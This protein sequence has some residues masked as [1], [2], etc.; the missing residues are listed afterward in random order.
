MATQLQRFAEAL[1]PD[2]IRCLGRALQP[3]SVGHILLLARLEHPLVLGRGLYDV[4]SLA[5]GVAVC[6]MPYDRVVA[7]RDT[8]WFRCWLHWLGVK[9]A[10]DLRARSVFTQYLIQGAT[11]PKSCVRD[12]SGNTP[13]AGTPFWCSVLVTMQGDLGMSLSQALSVPAARALW[14]CSGVWEG[15]GAI[16][17]AT[18]AEME[19]LGGTR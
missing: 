7:S 12:L 9:A 1:F 13:S 4:A 16:Q 18:D 10:R 17:V 8:W 5:L 19:I 6:S 2:T 3:L 11:G 15:K 14:L